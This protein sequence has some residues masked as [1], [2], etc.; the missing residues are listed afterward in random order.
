MIIG[1]YSL[2]NTV[3]LGGLISAV[4][5][6]FLAGH[7][8][9]GWAL[10]LFFLACVCDLF[11]GRIARSRPMNDEKRKLFGIQLDSICDMVSFGVT[12]CFIAYSMG[13][14]GIVD[15]AVY[16][17]FVA[18]GAIRLSFFNTLALANPG[19][20]TKYY[21]G[22]P[23]PVNCFFFTLIVLLSTFLPE[24]V[25]G[26]IFPIFFVIF[27][28]AFIVN[29]KIKKPPLKPML[30]IYGVQIVLLIITIIR[31]S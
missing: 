8:H 5:A 12:P 26:W 10:G 16:L 25:N 7:G 24:A 13:F 15:I 9:F 30:I 17:L 20:P 23:I 6:C 14:N 29:I 28:L 18:C 11:D 4:L 21:R 3:T 27:G 22:L 31:L 19:K 2:A 1:Y